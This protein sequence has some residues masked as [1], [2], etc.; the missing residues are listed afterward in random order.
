MVPKF[1]TVL[2]ADIDKPFWHAVMV[3]FALA[4]IRKK[5]VYRQ[6]TNFQFPKSED[7]KLIEPIQMRELISG[8]PASA[9]IFKIGDEMAESLKS[10]FSLT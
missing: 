9:Q 1:I 2:D 5:Q 3:D 6:D 10:V 8:L 4:N 7:D